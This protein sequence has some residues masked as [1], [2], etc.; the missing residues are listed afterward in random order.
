[1][2]P[3]HWRRRLFLVAVCAAVVSC[4]GGGG[5]TSSDSTYANWTGSANGSVI[6]DASNDSFEVESATGAL[7]FNRSNR[8]SGVL[9]SSSG[10]MSY[11]GTASGSVV[12]STATNGARISTLVCNSGVATDI[13]V[14]GNSWSWNCD[15]TASSQPGSSTTIGTANQSFTTW[16]GSLNGSLLLDASGDTFQVDAATR[17]MSDANSGT[18]FNNTFIYADASIAIG[19]V[20]VGHVQLVD[21]AG[22]G[23][24]AALVCLSGARMDIAGSGTQY[25]YACPGAAAIP[26]SSTPPNTGAATSNVLFVQRGEYVAT[27][28]PNQFRVYLTNQSAFAIACS[29]FG[30]YNYPDGKGGL[31]S[32]NRTENITVASGATDYVTFALVSANLQM[33]NWRSVCTRV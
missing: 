32:D 25:T 7:V 19:G 5:D 33:T 2:T 11:R 20:T 24:V 14:T 4:G 9:I 15:V 27:T 12:L 1:M 6:K 3:V 13:A 30:T 10:A 22:A 26:V 18:S 23:K 31:G 8:L 28:T 17:A 29:I 21:A 16:S